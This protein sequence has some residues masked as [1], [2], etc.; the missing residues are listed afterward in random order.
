MTGRAGGDPKPIFPS[1]GR[2]YGRTSDIAYLIV[3]LTAGLM[4]IP[5]GWTKVLAGIPGVSG[6]F[7]RLGL[8]PSW[9]YTIIS[10]FNETV[11]G[12]LIAIGLATRPVAALIIIEFLILLFVV[13]IPRGYGMAVGGA[14]FPL[15]WLLM[16][17]VVLLRG[18]GPYSLDRAIG[19]EI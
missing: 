2:Y 1:L 16:L 12:I 15:M 8:E 6:Y 19:R 18:G 9:M 17:V 11:G 14:E 3:R 4:L 10:M 7:T 5:H 13:H